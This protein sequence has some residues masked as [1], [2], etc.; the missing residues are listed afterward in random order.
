MSTAEEAAAEEACQSLCNNN[1]PGKCAT[2]SNVDNCCTQV[3]SKCGTSLHPDA[4]GLPVALVVLNLPTV[5]AV[6]FPCLSPTL[7]IS[8]HVPNKIL[9]T[10]TDP[11]SSADRVSRKKHPSPRKLRPLHRSLQHL[12][13][14]SPSLR[15][16]SYQCRRQARPRV[17]LDSRRHTLALPLLSR[18]APCYVAFS[19]PTFFPTIGFIES[20]NLLLPFT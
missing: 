13:C 9:G 5:L 15:H 8:P 2:G 14:P 20:P 11:H 1:I 12:L 3:C 4:V 6:S 18:L 17:Q 16:L 7:A 10:P 19:A